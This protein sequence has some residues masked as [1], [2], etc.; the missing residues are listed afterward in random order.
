MTKPVDGLR[1]KAEKKLKTRSTRPDLRK[2]PWSDVEKIVYEL[3]VHQVELE[4]QN[5]ELRQAQE[6]LQ[7]SRLKYFDLFELAPVGYLIM[8]ASGI[9]KEANLTAALLLG[10]ERA[11]LINRTFAQYVDADYRENWLSLLTGLHESQTKNS[12]EVRLIKRDR[13]GGARY[14]HVE[15]MTVAEN[16]ELIRVN[17]VDI[18][19]RKRAAEALRESEAFVNKALMSS[20]SGLFIYDF[21]T[22]KVVFINPQYTA[23]TGYTLETL[24]SMSERRFFG[25]FHPDDRPRLNAQQRLLV[26]AD[27]ND[28]FELEVRFKTADDRWIRVMSRNA[29]F[30]RGP[31]GG[32]TQV[33]GSIIDITARRAAEETLL[34][35]EERYYTLFEKIDEGFCIVEVLFDSGDRAIDY[36]FLETN[37]AFD[38]QTGLHDA[39][40]KRMREMVPDHEDHW[41]EIYGRIA[42]TG[43]PER[44]TK[45]AKYLDNRWYDVYAFRVGRPEERKVAILFNDISRR[46]A[47]EEA[48]RKQKEQMRLLIDGLPALV[49]FVDER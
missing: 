28:V 13:D 7:E 2:I 4:L 17:L 16:K 11:R 38:E 9:I 49:A 23:I 8:N 36:R 5:E 21:T 35:T 37:P 10:I 33:I 19:A 31:K 43:E 40:G 46:K 30:A 3:E 12:C 42:L 18:T 27:E 39:V 14:F 41:F 15:G 44:F 26:K 22:S 29:V 48:L 6:D 47:A 20:L 45:V 1:R 34:R 25:L 32:V 24:N